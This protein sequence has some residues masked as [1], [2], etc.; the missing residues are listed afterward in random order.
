MMT[1]HKVHGIDGP[2]YADYL[3]CKGGSERPGDY[4]LGR[5]GRPRENAGTWHGLACEEL[6]LAGTV[7]REDLMRVWEGRDPRSGEVLVRRGATGDHVAGIDATFSAPKSVSVLWALSDPT[8]RAA[9][10]AAH[11]TAV[12]TG[13]RHIES[14]VEL[15]RRRT[16]DQIVHERVAGIIA[17]RFRH[18]TARLTAEQCAAGVAPDP[19]LHDHLV[20]ANMA[21]RERPDERGNRWAAVDS[22][23]IY[24]VAA[25]AG[26]VYRA[27]LAAGLQRLGYSITRTGRYFEVDGIDAQLRER[28]S[29]R[30][31]ELAAA[32]RE[33]RAEHGRGPTP[34]ERK[35]L[36]L[37]TRQA[38]SV[39]HA[40][41]F[42]Q[43]R[44][45]AGDIVL[46]DPVFGPPA[47][48]NREAVAAA[49]IADLTD[50]ASAHFVTRDAAVVDDRPL[51]TAI[52]EAAQGRI[53]G[54]EI[55]WLIAE[56]QDSPRFQRLDARH[57]TTAATLAMEA[58]VMAHAEKLNAASLDVPLDHVDTA[59][60]S[61][62]VALSVE[63]Q[64]AVQRLVESRFGILAAPAGAGKGEVLRATAE[65]RH[66]SGQR[67]IALAAAG[68]TAQRLGRDIGA[69]L[70]MT[71]EGFTRRVAQRRLIIGAKDAIVID[72]AGLLE[73]WRWLSVLRASKLATLTVTG[74]PA[75]LSSI[76]AGGLFTVMTTRLDTVRLTENFRARDQWAKDTWAELRAGNALSAVARLE[77]KRQ[78]VISRTRAESREAAVERWDQDRR[79]GAARGRGIEQ[80]L[81]LA[82]TSNVDV[83]LLNA[84]AQDRRIQARELTGPSV[85][86][87]SPR[88]DGG[89]R[90]ERLRSGDLVSFTR[91]V[92]FGP[93]RPRVEKGASGTV[94]AVHRDANAVDVQLPWRTV[95]ISDDDL[96]A[97]RLGYAQH[98]YVSQGRTVDRVYAITGGWQTAREGSYVA[99]S[100]AREASYIYTDHSSLDMETT[101][102]K[103][104]LR[105]LVARAATSRTQV[106]AIGWAEHQEAVR[107]Q[108]SAEETRQTRGFAALRADRRRALH[109]SERATET[110]ESRAAA[111]REELERRR[112]RDAQRRAEEMQRD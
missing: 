56:V 49:V 11:D 26:A 90:T 38:K 12:L 109:T 17:A 85:E 40:P 96:S 89:L 59:I 27:E 98:L 93:G 84:A 10:E 16:G 79:E 77:R 24:R 62:R 22:L 23:P 91:Q 100:R 74:D 78:I 66:A 36:T 1:V 33:F 35:A 86:V 80:Y 99:V 81:L 63:Q 43:W 34:T 48:V 18:H 110:E 76:E 31:G 83:D 111:A 21:L 2:G 47:R 71:L 103:A 51:R 112:E 29:A 73:D 65:V 28:F 45:R 101:N 19:Q 15:A 37:M 60:Q 42:D 9:V 87:R 55:P 13:L 39:E 52:A 44:A 108:R 46:P 72:E 94:I 70:A 4:Y 106:A 61:A 97:L 82:D 32:V 8:T 14:T 5:S 67:V 102:R 105:E 107:A 50:P 92:Y 95:T 41:A 3:T 104:A 68:E 30:S 75:Q 25:E 64:G 88:D 69:D 58:E 54:A 53:G 20:I 57:W 6:G 7:R